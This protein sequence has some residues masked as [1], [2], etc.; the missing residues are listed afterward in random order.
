MSGPGGNLKDTCTLSVWR[1]F[2]PYYCGNKHGLIM[3]VLQRTRIPDIS[4]MKSD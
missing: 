2:K 3:S 4:N 1:E